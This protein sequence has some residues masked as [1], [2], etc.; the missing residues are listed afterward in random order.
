[1]LCACC[2]DGS[3]MEQTAVY[4]KRTEGC[5]WKAILS[6]QR[7]TR[8]RCVSA[9]ALSALKTKLIHQ[10]AAK[11][12]NWFLLALFGHVSY[13][14]GPCFSCTLPDVLLQDA[15]VQA[16]RGTWQNQVKRS[17]NSHSIKYMC[18]RQAWGFL[19]IMVDDWYLT[20][21]WLPDWVFIYFL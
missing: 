19:F 18:Y 20:N 14:R 17:R 15:E 1:M 6:P 3:V 8:P 11:W 21:Q 7:S 16:G 10:H 2:D 12:C 9:S 13:Q 5:E 4:W